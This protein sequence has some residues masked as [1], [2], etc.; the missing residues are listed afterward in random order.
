MGRL[1]DLT[2]Y[3]MIKLSSVDYWLGMV[4]SYWALVQMSPRFP[5]DKI[6]EL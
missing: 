2:V 1:Y 5:G 6:G 3:Y 4:Y